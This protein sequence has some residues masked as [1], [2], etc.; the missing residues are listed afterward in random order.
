LPLGRYL[1][2]IGK[3]EHAS[4]LSGIAVW[5]IKVVVFAWSGACAALAGIVMAARTGSGN[6][7]I[8]DSL[9]LPSI[10]A[11]VVGG[12]SITG[13]HGGLWRAF[14]GALIISVMRVGIT[15]TGIHPAYEPIVYGVILVLAAALTFDRSTTVNVK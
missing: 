15:L 5:R 11:V 2:A 12:T 9:L 7:T 6:P 8:A 13:G 4:L 1:Y 10:A 3:N 14:V